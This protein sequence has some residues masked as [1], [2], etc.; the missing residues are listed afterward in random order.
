MI[1][2]VHGPHLTSDASFDLMITRTSTMRRCRQHLLC[3]WPNIVGYGS[4]CVCVCYR[5]YPD[6]TVDSKYVPGE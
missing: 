5:K 1:L 6:L 4:L 3:Y 2:S